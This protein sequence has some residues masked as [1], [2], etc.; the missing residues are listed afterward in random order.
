MEIQTLGDGDTSNNY[1][2]VDNLLLE[3]LGSIAIP[4][5]TDKFMIRKHF[6]I[7][8]SEKARVRIARFGFNFKEHFLWSEDG[9]D[10]MRPA[11]TMYCHQVKKPV[12]SNAIIRN[13]GA[14]HQMETTLDMMFALMEKQANKENSMLL[15]N[16]YANIFFVR[17]D[18]RR[19]LWTVFGSWK[20]GWYIDAK[21]SGVDKWHEGHRVFSLAKGNPLH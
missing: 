20:N 14:D 21:L 6:I 12:Q 16:G 19:V 11:A 15:L 4:A 17:D 2:A 8:E 3:P 13:L 7:D 9:A 5:M 10:P 1:G 18:N